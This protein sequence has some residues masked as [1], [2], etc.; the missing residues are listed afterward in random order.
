VRDLSRSICLAFTVPV[1]L[2]FELRVHT[3][4]VRTAIAD[5]PYRK[6]RIISTGSRTLDTTLQSES[7]FTVVFVKRQLHVGPFVLNV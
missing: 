2:G 5:L 3:V 4:R 6:V 7:V 1:S